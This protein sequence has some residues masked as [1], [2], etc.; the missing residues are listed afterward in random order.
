[1]RAD[2]VLS[3]LPAA[4]EIVCGL[5]AIERL[6]GRSHECDFPPAVLR[7]PIASTPRID[8]TGRAG[9]IDAGVRAVL[10]QGL[11]VYQVDRDRIAALAPDFILTQTLCAVC[12]V[13][14]DDLA[15]IVC[16]ALPSQPAV[17]SLDAASLDGLWADI[18]RVAAALGRVAQG[19]ALVHSLK[20]RLATLAATPWP[21]RPRIACLEWLDPLMGAGNWMPE[22]VAAAGGAAVFGEAGVHTAPTSWEDLAAA[23][24]DVILIAACGWPIERSRAEMAAVVVRPLWQGLRAV[25]LGRVYVADGHHYFNRPG[26][27]LVES[28]EILAEILHPGAVTARHRGTGWEPFRQR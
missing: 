4:T 10:E 15:L 14:P 2:R 27:R 26:P 19:E 3:L 16:E 23:D 1:M 5:G 11:S 18:G 6:V 22:L 17:V 24:P 12:A 7:L 8:I 13:S 28:A 9:A 21:G 20:A 25:R